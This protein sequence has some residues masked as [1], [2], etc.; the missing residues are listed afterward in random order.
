MDAQPNRDAA[1]DWA[2]LKGVK[3]PVRNNVHQPGHEITTL[4]YFRIKKGGFP[5]F[6]RVS[7]EGV[8][9]YFEKMGVRVVGLWQVVPGPREDEGPAREYDEVYLM[10]RYA[11]MKHWLATRHTARHAGNGPD[12]QKQQEAA[13]VRRSMILETRVLFLEGGLAPNGPYFM[14]GLEEYYQEIVEQEES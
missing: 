9:P 12:W 1:G 5:E 11:G 2:G 10:S 4:R 6:R 7:E 14:P 3:I 8:W 13:R